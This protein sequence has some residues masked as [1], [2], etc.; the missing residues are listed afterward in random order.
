MA[1]T[2]SVEPDWAKPSPKS[3]GRTALRIVL[4]TGCLLMVLMWIGIFTDYFAKTA[5]GTL[6]DKAFPA[7]AQ[8]ICTTAKTKLDGLKKAFETTNHVDRANEVA[9][10]NV[11]MRDMVDQL[12]AVAPTAG[13]DGTMTQEWLGDWSTYLTNR[14]DYVNRLR[15]DE[16]ARFLESPKSSATEQISKPI[17]RF[18]YVNK[19]DQCDTPK[20]MS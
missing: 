9:K 4:V 10:S 8:P 18:A 20:D 15:V 2:P 3:K 13:R 19:M 5:P 1:A 6:D 11:I 14:E 16:K 7:A 17:D 12:A